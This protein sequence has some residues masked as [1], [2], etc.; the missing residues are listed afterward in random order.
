[1]AKE[2]YYFVTGLPSLG[3][4][5]SKIAWNTLEFLDYA[6][7]YTTPTDLNLMKLLLLP[8]DISNLI[9][10]IHNKETW[11]EDSLVSK[12]N[13]LRLIEQLQPQKD[14]SQINRK[15][16]FIKLPSFITDYVY[17]QYQENTIDSIQTMEFCLYNNFYRWV[18][19]K[20]NAYIRAWF[21]FDQALRNILIAL[22]CRKFNLS[23]ENQIVGHGEIVERL[24]SSHSTD[25]GLNK[26]FPIFD[27]LNRIKDIKDIFEREKAIDQLRWKWIDNQNFFQYFTIDRIL[28]YYCKIIMLNRWMSL[29]HKE[30]ELAFGIILQNLEDSFSFPEEF[31]INRR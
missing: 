14:D 16:D 25:F 7:Q 31:A 21:T 12:E 15:V 20:N 26:E 18:C 22:N 1:M 8:N 13:W 19:K 23:L 30:G 24:L 6:G 28:G 11:R 9:S 2:Y 10:V 4:D 5:D 17:D 29:S 3:I 27:Q